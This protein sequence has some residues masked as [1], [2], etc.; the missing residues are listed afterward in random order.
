MNTYLSS[1]QLKDE[2][3]DK[4][5][6]HYGILIGCAVLVSV[7]SSA[8]SIIPMFFSA[9]NTLPAFF[10]S[11]AI[12]FIL[13]VFI[14][15]FS[16]GTTLIYMKLS[17]GSQASVSDLFYGFSHIQTALG[18]SLVITGL[19]TLLGLSYQI[20]FNLYR[21]TGREVYY[22][23]TFLCLALALVILIPL[24]IALSQCCFL[25]LDFPNKSAKE[26]L[27]LSF[28]ITKGHRLRL[29]YIQ[30]TFIPLFLLGI[31]SIIGL[32]W[33]YPYFNMTMTRFYFDI[34]KPV[35]KN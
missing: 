34:M 32:L 20:P 7:I 33:V 10:L 4:L 31:L 17:H 15:V 23:A 28:R 2:A 13:S 25:M 26:L 21:F 16:I 12:S 18:I 11:E 35:Q 19:S 24:S 27:A 3:K 1:S 6:G 30:V 29:F 9:S 14:G 22:F 8:A 5:T